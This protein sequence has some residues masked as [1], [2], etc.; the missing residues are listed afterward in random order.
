MQRKIDD[1]SPPVNYYCLAF[2][3]YALLYDLYHRRLRQTWKLPVYQDISICMIL[4]E[5]HCNYYKL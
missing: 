4:I 1:Q 2:R 3:E 5:S